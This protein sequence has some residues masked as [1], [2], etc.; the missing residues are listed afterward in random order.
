[1]RRGRGLTHANMQSTLR[2]LFSNSDELTNLRADC[3]VGGSR[4]DGD[5]AGMCARFHLQLLVRELQVVW[6]GDKI[7]PFANK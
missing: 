2:R 3:V 7:R 5:S 1:M 6:W 4:A